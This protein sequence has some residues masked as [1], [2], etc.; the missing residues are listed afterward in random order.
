MAGF[1]VGAFYAPAFDISSYEL[2]AEGASYTV[3]GPAPRIFSRGLV[4]KAD[5]GRY[6]VFGGDNTR[7]V[8]RVIIA[9]KITYQVTGQAAQF[10][11]GRSF[12]ADGG[13]YS[14]IGRSADVLR[15][16]GI[17]ANTGKYKV[18]GKSA[19][20]RFGWYLYPAAGQ[21]K[22]TGTNIP[23][24]ADREL[25]AGLGKYTYTGFAYNLRA[26]RKFPASFGQYNITI[27]QNRMFLSS[28]FVGDSEIVVV[29]P[30]QIVS[31]VS[32]EYASM[33]ITP[34]R[35]SVDINS[36]SRAAVVVRGPI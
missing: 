36:E 9:D 2:V 8:G 18:T 17:V 20:L 16:R 26:T 15:G 5:R 31:I 3:Y 35:N 21:Y 7:L 24:T 32:G 11:R 6:Y 13:I 33:F 30:E 19:V 23:V 25:Y 10:L 4:V 28:F 1:K 14:V 29:R 22:I 27:Q 34:A 12:L